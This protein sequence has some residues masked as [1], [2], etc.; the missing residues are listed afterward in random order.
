MGLIQDDQRPGVLLAFVL[1]CT[2]G[3]DKMTKDL[4]FYWLLF[5][6][7]P[8]GRQDDQRPGVLLAFVLLCAMG[9]T[10]TGLLWEVLV[11]FYKAVAYSRNLGIWIVVHINDSVN[12]PDISVWDWIRHQTVILLQ[13]FIAVQT[14]PLP[15]F[16]QHFKKVSRI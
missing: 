1:L 11:Y 16:P 7:V 5:F 9:G 4:E 3:G 6:S 14:C 13:N 8:W 12:N 15:L 10:Q 2:M